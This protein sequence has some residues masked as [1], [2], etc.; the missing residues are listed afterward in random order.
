MPC[1]G[2]GHPT[3]APHSIPSSLTSGKP[4]PQPAGVTKASPR[5]P[6]ENVANY[7]SA[8]WRKDLDHI[9]GSFFHYNHPSHKEE[10]WKKLRTRFFDY[11]GQSQ[12]EWRA[13]KEDKPLKY[14]P[15]MESRFHTL[16]GVKLTG[17]SQFTGWM[18][19]GSYYHGLVARKG[20][21]HRCLHLA[22]IEPP[23]GLQVCPSQSCLVTQ[24]EETPTTSPPTLGREGGTPQGAHSD[25]P[26]PM[27]TGGAG[28]G[29]SW[30]EEAKASVKEEWRGRPTKHRQSLSRRWEGRSTH[31]FRLQDSEGREEVVQQL[32]RHASELAPAR[33]D[34]AAQGMARHH[35]DIES[36]MAKSLN[37]Q[38]L[39]MISEYHLTCLSQGSSYISPVLP[40]VAKDLLPS[41]EE[42]MTGSGFQGTQDL[43][44]LEKAK[45][46]WVAVWLHC[47][48]MATAG[49]ETASY[50]LDAA[51][52]GRGPLLEFLLALQASSLTFEEVVHRVLAENRSRIESSPN[53]VQ[54][55]R[56]WLQ[57]ELEDLS[58]AHKDEPVK[59]SQKKLK[60][61][62]EQRQR[63]LKGLEATIS[64]YDCS[65]GRAR[66]R[67]EDAPASEDD[68]SDTEAKGAMATTLVAN[69]APPVS[70]TPESLTSPP[71][72]EQTRPME[73]DDRDEHQPPASPIFHREDELLTGDTAV[74][75]EGEMANLMVSSPRGC[76]GGD[77][78]ASI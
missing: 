74:G 10:D 40:E 12:E 6:L 9:L 19:P 58:W 11:L 51:R 32:Y 24:K 20:Q 77:E 16:T 35:P 60:R 28:D 56:A 25:P 4:L 55:L 76:D 31:P 67:P 70:T 26:T 64:Q 7:R 69:D 43:R 14:M 1:Q 53:K 34:V 47:L 37:N 54:E 73:V 68:Q 45:T 8:G 57:G 29:Q 38:A 2:G 15:Y 52:H 3:G 71:D 72:E 78:G 39:C 63:D 75:V 22:G 61:E 66:A 62:M 42:Y 46:L 50:S 48:D 65:L 18:K 13:I 30:A 17:L 21:L 36:G 49:D 41:E 27:E 5:N 59:S 23:K 33:H 44:V